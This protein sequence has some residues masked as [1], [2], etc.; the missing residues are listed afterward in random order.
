VKGTQR[1]RLNIMADIYAP[2]EEEPYYNV[3]THGD[4]D[5][6]QETRRLCR[7]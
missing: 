3:V 4:P 7:S 5:P 1:H 2:A 6:D